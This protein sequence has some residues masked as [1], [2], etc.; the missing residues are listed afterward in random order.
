[1]VSLAVARAMGLDVPDD[2][3]AVPAVTTEHARN[4]TRGA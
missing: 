1:M 4:R 3:A 2:D